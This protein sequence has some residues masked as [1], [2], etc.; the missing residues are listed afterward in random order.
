MVAKM[1]KA[2][3]IEDDADTAEILRLYLERDGLEVL[4]ERDGPGGLQIAMEQD[5]DI[6]LLDLMLPGLD[7]RDLCRRLR[8]RSEVPVLMISARSQVDQRIEGF[9]L[10]ADDY[11]VKPFS[12]REVIRRVRA[13]LRRAGEAPRLD[14]GRLSMD[15]TQRTVSV[16]KQIL[17]LTSTEWALLQTLMRS[18]RRVFSRDDLIAMLGRDFEGFSRSVDAHIG[19]LRKKLAAAGAP[20]TTIQTVVGFGY[21]L[22]EAPG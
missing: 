10:G 8:A 17:Q 16:G 21:R 19:N 5:P 13:L 1:A 18:P 2:L 20:R 12:P 7:G 22:G 11:V 3:I 4:C 15:L 9:D 14:H 6:V